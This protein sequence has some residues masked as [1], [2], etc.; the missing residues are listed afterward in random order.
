MLLKL[1]KDKGKLCLLF[2]TLNSSVQKR[3]CITWPLTW[4]L[5]FSPVPTAP[6][7]LFHLF[8]FWSTH[9]RCFVDVF[10]LKVERMG[11]LWASVV[12]TA[13]ANW[14]FAREPLRRVPGSPLM[15]GLTVWA[16]IPRL[17]L[18]SR[19]LWGHKQSFCPRELRPGGGIPA[20]LPQ[21]GVSLITELYWL[22]N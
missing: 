18:R 10:M 19:A 20:S 17:M 13:S 3:P 16:H 9:N 14:W 2:S 6:W 5:F 22:A 7:I 8:V 4:A 21:G 1:Q 15:D 11:P 12:T